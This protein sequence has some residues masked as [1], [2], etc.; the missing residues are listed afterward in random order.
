VHAPAPMEQWMAEGWP[1]GIPFRQG[2][3]VSSSAAREPRLCLSASVVASYRLGATAAPAI[4]R[5]FFLLHA[6]FLNEDCRLA[7]IVRPIPPQP[8]R[9]RLRS[10]RSPPARASA[11]RW[12]PP[13][14]PLPPPA[15]SPP[16]AP[17]LAARAMS[18]GTS[19]APRP[20]STRPPLPHPARSP[21]PWPGWLAEL[22]P[23]DVAGRLLSSAAGRGL[24]HRRARLRGADPRRRRWGLR[25]RGRQGTCT[26]RS[27]STR[28]R[29]GTP[30]RA[31]RAPPTPPNPPHLTCD[32]ATV[33]ANSLQRVCGLLRDLGIS[34]E[35]HAYWRTRRRR[36]A[37]SRRTR[38]RRARRRLV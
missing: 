36:T 30:R 23:A 22:V 35:E 27:C 3:A 14:P 34:G 9:S 33:F 2:T 12:P 38:R 19:R 10:P 7:L 4:R 24:P 6:V 28:R 1:A 13:R 31:Y 8:A 18:P 16:R 5:V 17:C 11:I 25:V 20:P 29:A 26:T 32:A 15:S 37:M 21:A